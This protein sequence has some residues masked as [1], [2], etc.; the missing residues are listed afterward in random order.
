MTAKPSIQITFRITNLGG[1]PEIHLHDQ[2]PL[3]E[4]FL[5]AGGADLPLARQLK[6]VGEEMAVAMVRDEVQSWFDELFAHPK[7]IV[8]KVDGVY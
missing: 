5:A 7:D 4:R 3:V 8:V 2:Q 1:L 6:L